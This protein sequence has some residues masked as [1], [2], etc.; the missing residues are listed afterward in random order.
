[1][2]PPAWMMRLQ[3]GTD[4]IP[5][6]CLQKRPTFLGC[7]RISQSPRERPHNATIEQIKFR[8]CHLLVAWFQFPRLEPIAQQS[9]RQNL[10]I[11]L[12]GGSPD[13][14]LPCDIRNIR[15]LTVLSGRHFQKSRKSSHIPGRRLC[16]DFLIQIHRRIGQEKTPGIRLHSHFWQCPPKHRPIRIKG[17][18]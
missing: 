5:H 16:P 3:V 11:I 1:M 2:D 8:M 9:I 4:F 18:A 15:Y 17:I 10:K 13:S 6:Q 12:H 14:R 7:R